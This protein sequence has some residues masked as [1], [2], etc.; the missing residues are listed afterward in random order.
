MLMRY[1]HWSHSFYPMSVDLPE[2]QDIYFRAKEEAYVL[3]GCMHSCTQLLVFDA[4]Q[5]DPVVASWLFV[6]MQEYFSY[7]ARCRDWVCHM[8]L[9]TYTQC[10]HRTRSYLGCTASCSTVGPMRHDD[11]LDLLSGLDAR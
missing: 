11:L 6:E 1:I 2:Q 9:A 10:L 7:D 4:C 5:E 3:Q 8:P